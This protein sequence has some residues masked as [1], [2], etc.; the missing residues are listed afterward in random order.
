MA[1]E[2]FTTNIGGKAYSYTQ[3]S[4]RESLLLKLKILK[5]AGVSIRHIASAKGVNSSKKQME[6]FSNAISSLVEGSSPEEILSLIER[7]FE[8]GFCEN[9]R[10]N[11]DVHF[12]NSMM[13]MYKV[14]FWMM[15][16]EYGS[17][18]AEA[19]SKT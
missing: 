9:E 15:K 6:A 3:L 5:V 13:D 17:F 19:Q 7:V 10:I 16:M 14:L 4:A 1:C 11:I 2:T 8:H 12:E 18:L